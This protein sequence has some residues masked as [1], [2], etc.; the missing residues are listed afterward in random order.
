MNLKAVKNAERDAKQKE[1]SLLENNQ[2]TSSCFKF[3]EFSFPQRS[4]SAWEMIFPLNFSGLEFSR[5]AFSR[6]S[7][8]KLLK[9]L[10]TLRETLQNKA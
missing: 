2:V 8:W 10:K 5:A 3:E 9:D 4:R 7:Q 1:D 6:T